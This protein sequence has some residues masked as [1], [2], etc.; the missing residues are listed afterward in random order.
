M[1][2][3]LVATHVASFA[4]NTLLH[5][6]VDVQVLG[7]DDLRLIVLLPDLG[8]GLDD[9]LQQFGSLKPKGKRPA[10]Q[11]GALSIDLFFFH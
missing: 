2:G 6:A 8:E 7:E 1:D 10:R 5:P 9:P 3:A 11:N 4:V